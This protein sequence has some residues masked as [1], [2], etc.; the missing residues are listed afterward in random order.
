MIGSMKDPRAQPHPI[1]VSIADGLS[2]VECVTAVI[3]GA[4]T[5][6][7]CVD[8]SWPVDEGT[9][10]Y[11]RANEILAALAEQWKRE[12]IP[13]KVLVLPGTFTVPVR[14]EHVLFQRQPR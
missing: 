2:R 11:D 5:L 13:F 14:W 12:P 9:P 10:A 3:F 7:V 1:A 6:V 4:D 8:T